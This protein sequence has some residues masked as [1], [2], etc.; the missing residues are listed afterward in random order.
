MLLA[1][2]HHMATTGGGTRASSSRPLAVFLNLP[3]DSKFQS[4]FLAY[5]AGVTAFGLSPRAT[6][7]IPGG[8][9][10][11]DR[12]FQII[13]ECRYSVHDLSRVQ[14]DRVSPTTPRFNMPFELGLAVAHERS[15][16]EHAWFVFEQMPWRIMKS[17]SDLNGTDVHIHGGRIDGVF[18]EL[19][20]ALAREERQPTVGQMWTI[21]REVR[22]AVPA[23]LRR[24][25]SR[26]LFEARPFR[27]LSVIASNLADRIVEQPG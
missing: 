21:Y 9:R 11:L 16:K 6:L 8:M 27:D 26:T 14:L 20:N 24:T 3:Y 15:G 17:L 23:I 12:I 4:L 25:G 10:R 18:R 22:S 13:S 7:E 5:I 19:C 2:A 1:R